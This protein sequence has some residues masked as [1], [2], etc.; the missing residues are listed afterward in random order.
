MKLLALVQAKIVF[1]SFINDFTNSTSGCQCPHD[2]KSFDCPCCADD[3]S[4]PCFWPYEDRCGDCIS[5]AGCVPEPINTFTSKDRGCYCETKDIREIDAHK[6][7]C[8]SDHSHCQCP[9]PYE[10]MC[11]PC[12]DN[13]P[14]A[15]AAQ[16]PFD[17]KMI[18]PSHFIDHPQQKHRTRA[19]QHDL[20]TAP[21]DEYCS[22]M[23]EFLENGHVLCDPSSKEGKSCAWI[24]NPGYSLVGPDHA[25]CTCDSGIGCGWNGDVQFEPPI[26]IKDQKSP[27]EE[28]PCLHGRCIVD[29]KNEFF[30]DCYDGW[31]GF[32]CH[33]PD[34][35]HF[36]N[37]EHSFGMSADEANLFFRSD[38]SPTNQQS[39]NYDMER[40]LRSRGDVPSLPEDQKKLVIEDHN[41]QCPD[42]GSVANGRIKCDNFRNPGSHCLLQCEPGYEVSD[43]KFVSPTCNCKNHRCRWDKRRVYKIS[44]CWP[45]PIT[46]NVNDALYDAE[47]AGDDYL[48]GI[49]S[50]IMKSQSGVTSILSTKCFELS[51]PNFGKI[52]CTDDAKNE[53]VCR[54]SCKKGY[55]LSNSKSA[56]CSCNSGDCKWNG[57]T[58]YK[59]PR[60]EDRDECALN[61]HKC[62]PGN[63]CIN[64]PG[65]FVCIP[66][67]S[68]L[69]R[70][71]DDNP[72][73]AGGKCK[74]TPIGYKCICGPGYEY[75]AGTCRDINE[76]AMNVSK[77]FDDAICEN[78]D[79]GYTCKCPSGFGDAINECVES[80]SALACVQKRTLVFTPNPEHVAPNACC[81]GITFNTDL[82]CCCSGVLHDLTNGQPCPCLKIDY[83]II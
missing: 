12:E 17:Y 23:E 33:V 7:A 62:R 5:G 75:R 72:C 14:A 74:I 11:V 54:F 60:C 45:L 51:E 18:Y 15:C 9:P 78:N 19:F 64:K 13:M 52:K 42:L 30:C 56:S 63:T 35:S 8:C 80:R 59:E 48:D 73:G 65:S 20:Y 50:E 41:R 32:Y 29:I 1:G 61:T 49:G 79:G 22:E 36:D 83:S 43:T 81:Q 76:C 4:C 55:A 82:K 38:V 27:C 37:S 28:K 57:I 71:C 53:S 21:K 34:T 24:C 2:T 10:N 77:C 66:N 69:L 39:E 44:S 16:A 40:L 47:S 46:D 6:C 26:C 58:F 31:T 3:N 25:K 68:P 70:Q 67:D